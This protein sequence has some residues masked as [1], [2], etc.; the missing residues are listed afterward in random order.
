MKKFTFLPLFIVLIF[1][2]SMQTYGQTTLYES[3]FDDMNVGDFL[4]Q[5]DDSGFWTTWSD[6]PGGAEDAQVTDAQS[7]SPSNSVNVEGSTDLIF[8]MGN[9]TSGKYQF[10]LKYYIEPNFG[11]YIN[12][13]HFEVPGTEWAFEVYFGATEQG[14]ITVGG[15]DYGFEFNAGEWLQLSFIFNLDVDTAQFFL[16]DA[17]V[18]EWPFHFKA[19]DENGTMQLGGADIYAGAPPGEDPHYY[20]DDVAF[21]EL[22]AGIEAPHINIDTAPIVEILEEGEETVIEREMSNTGVS[23]LT[24]EIIPTYDFGSKAF[25]SNSTYE[26]PEYAKSLTREVKAVVN[27]NP[28]VQPNLSDRDEVLRYDDGA[29]S[30]A[31]GN[32][33][34][35]VWRVAAM[36]PHGM[37]QPFIGM[38]ITSVDVF[39]N[40][41]SLW[42][43]V[44][45][46]GM[47]SILTPGAGPL[48]YEQDFDPTAQSWNTITLDTPVPIEGEDLW[49]GYMFDKPGGVYTPGCDAGPAADNGDWMSH[50]ENLGWTHL[51]DVPELDFNWNIAAT[52]TGELATQW[53]TVTPEEGTLVEDEVVTV[54]FTLDAAGLTEDGYIAKVKIRSNDPEN[55]IITI[56]VNLVVVVGVNEN[57]ANQY[58]M[59]YPNPAN[60]YL[61]I[62]NMNGVISHVRLTNTVGQVVIDQTMNTPN[63]K[64]D[65]S[66][67]PTG[68]YM[69]TID[70]DNGVAVQKVIVE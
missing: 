20:F 52:L 70:T 23:D 48:L 13:Q 38:E 21:I 46:Y 54:T 16:N 56:P 19:S 39:I 44:Q 63:V 5:T 33:A 57:D 3:G 25:T 59:V 37:V 8:K 69:A 49:V 65:I 30:S 9:K 36:F 60:D 1:A 53:L 14:Y 24:Y 32:D 10:D 58:I 29:N 11:G 34:D 27:P 66:Q 51:S 41:L 62:S 35:Q 42:H 7:S 61:R 17:M 28:V 6:E 12:I 67:L 68:V 15:Q 26:F 4:A 47:G 64:V 55:E 43:K 22:V 2:Y 18:H 40:D 50:G 31:I 45:I